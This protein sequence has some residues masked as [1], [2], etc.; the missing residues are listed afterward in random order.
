MRKWIDNMVVKQNPNSVNVASVADSRR[1]KKKVK[2]GQGTMTGMPKCLQF[3]EAVQGGRAG[4]C[5]NKRQKE[6][7]VSKGGVVRSVESISNPGSSQSSNLGNNSACDGGNLLSQALVD[8]SDESVS[9]GGEANRKLLEARKIV[10]IQEGLGIRFSGDLNLE[11]RRGM[12]LED[13][14]K[15]KIVDWERRNSDQ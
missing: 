6:G 15:E 1:S 5:K 12:V 2:K 8:C 3:V 10:D 14:D 11:A 9:D 13:F 4:S 7:N